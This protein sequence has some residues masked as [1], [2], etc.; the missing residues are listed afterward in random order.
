MWVSPPA[1]T[2]A[3]SK[4]R[5]W[6]RSISAPSWFDWKNATSSPSS[7]ARAAIAG[8]DL[9]ER[10]APVD[11]GLA[12]AD[13]VEVRSLRGPGRVSSRARGGEERGCGT[14]RRSRARCRRGRPIPWRSGGPSA[15]AR[16]RASCQSRGGPGSFRAS[17]GVVRSP[18]RGDRAGEA[19]R[20]PRSGGVTPTSTP[21][22]VAARSPY[23]TASPWSKPPKPAAA[24]TACPRECPRF[25]VIRPPRRVALALV[26]DDDLD[27]RPRRHARPARQR[28]RTSNAAASP[29]AIAVAVAS[30]AART[31]AR[32]RGPPSSRLRRAQRGAGVRGASAAAAM[33]MTIGGRLME[34][35]DEVLALGQVD[36]GLAA[37]RGIDLGDEG[38][39][40]LDEPD[41]AQVVAARKPAASPSAPPPMATSDLG[42]LDVERGQLACRRLDDG[43]PLG[44]LALREQDVL[45]RR[46]PRSRRRVRGRLADGG[47]RA[48]LADEDRARASAARRARRPAHRP[49][50]RR[51]ARSGRSGSSRAGAW[52]RCREPAAIG[53]AASTES[54]TP[55]ISATPD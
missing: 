55:W 47:P 40:D 7:A 26:G 36:A 21:I 5:W 38:R 30:P 50:S 35:S 29:R 18:A 53:S 31:A 44:G 43:E 45:D 37:D 41:P 34:C 39:R 42:P 19:I 48:R 9:V 24:S 6:S 54:T 25:S 11:L 15:T 2:M 13:E 20:S 17:R 22:R 46:R 28:H 52:S 3:T 8:V 27:L 14:V 32:R 10:L 4:S 12:C 49:R 1:L 23:A 16:Q 51:R 33:S